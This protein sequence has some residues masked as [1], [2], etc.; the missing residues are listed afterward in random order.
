MLGIAPA[1]LAGCAG[2]ASS[3]LSPAARKTRAQWEYHNRF[4]ASG[5]RLRFRPHAAHGR[6][7]TSSMEYVYRTHRRD[8]RV[9]YAVKN[10]ATGRYLAEFQADKLFFGCSM[11][12]PAVAAVLLE[13]RRGNLTR[14]EF[15]NVVYVCDQSINASWFYL[16]ARITP[17]D[18]RNFEWKY[19]LPNVDIINNWQS[20]RFYAE[21]YERCVN[22]RLDY[23]CELLLEA[24]RRDQYGL[25][26]WVMPSSITYIGGKTGNYGEWDHES[27]FFYHRGTPYAIVLYTR[28]NFAPGNQ[29]G[30]MMGGLFRD[31]CA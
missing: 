3:L 31:Y 9:G 20:P 8:P 23:G 11:P 7:W 18:E 22:Y 17:A 28:G 21:F 12:K 2:P 14:E 5:A 19:H 16:L 6:P 25:G 1:A 15:Q 4:L 24:M 10:L 30:C 26:R 27:L 13:K 29:L